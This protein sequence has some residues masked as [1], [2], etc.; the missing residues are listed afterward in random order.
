MG[1]RGPVPKRSNTRA[2]HRA[3]ADR[4][5]SVKVEGRVPIPKTDTSWHPGARCWY[6]A[7]GR[8]GQSQRFEPSDWEFARVVA[9]FLSDQL[10]SPRPSAGMMRSLF[11]AMESLGSTESSRRRMKIEVE[12]NDSSAAGPVAPVRD[13]RLVDA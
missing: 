12:R 3:K 13:L 9:H 11:A 2:G 1:T 10:S 7:L 5:D 6:T 4:P 8:S